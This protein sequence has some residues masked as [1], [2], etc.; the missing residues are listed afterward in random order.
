MFISLT[1]TKGGV[2][3]STIAVHFAVWLY[4]QGASVALLDADKQCSSS[5]WI[6]EAEPKITARTAAIPEECLSEGRALAR[7]HDFV[8]GDSPGEDDNLS[9]TMLI[10]A[11]LAIFPIG[12]SILDFRSSANATAILAYAQKLRNERPEGRIVLNKIRRRDTISR[13]LEKAVRELG[14]RVA[15]NTVRELQAYRDA[16]QQGT[17]VTRMSRR[18]IPAAN[19][20]QQLFVELAGPSL[21]NCRV[22]SQNQLRKKVENE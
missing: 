8:V 21:M 16:A 5:Q 17:V 11:D 13:E 22:N 9:R 2:G 15:R 3:K 1:N 12:P 20:I 18:C 7:S 19:E 4:D 10:L 6:G 14:V